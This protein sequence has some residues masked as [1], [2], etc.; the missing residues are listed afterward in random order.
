M[1]KKIIRRTI[2][3]RKPKRIIKRKRIIKKKKVMGNQNMLKYMANRWLPLPPRY[4]TKLHTSFTGTITAGTASGNYYVKLNS[5][6]LP[7]NTTSPIPNVIGP[8]GVNQKEPSGLS[9]IY[10]N[11]LYQSYRVFAS[12]IKFKVTPGQLMDQIAVAIIPNENGVTSPSEVGVAM[13]QPFCKYKN[14]NPTQNNGWLYNNISV[15]KFYGVRPLA[16]KDDLS[17]QFTGDTSTAPVT[18]LFWKIIWQDLNN[19][20]TLSIGYEVEIT[21]FVEFFNLAAGNLQEI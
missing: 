12:S 7:F 11:N 17:G 6:I 5:V 16:I 20:V 15:A 3:K 18:Q 9:Q 8:L 1:P 10:G 14:F 21:H 4:I 2:I 13:Q 19:A